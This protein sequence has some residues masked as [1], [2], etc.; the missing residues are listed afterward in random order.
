M[1]KF[2]KNLRT[3]AKIIAF[4]VVTTMFATC[5]KKNGDEDDNGGTAS[6]AG[7]MIN[8]VKW[9]TCNVDAP[10]KFAAKPEA[11]GMFYQWDRKVAWATT[12]NITGWD[13]SPPPTDAEWSKANDP[14]PAGWRV[15]THDDI[16]TLLDL[17]K[18]SNEWTTVNGVGG[19]KFIDNAS[20]N[21]IF[22]PAVGYRHVNDGAL[23]GVDDESGGLGGFYWSSSRST[24]SGASRLGFGS[25][26]TD[27]NNGAGWTLYHVGYGLSV[28]PVAEKL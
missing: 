5:D 23:E 13:V 7:V 16:Q 21:S 6:N 24:N 9:A 3:V 17:V 10:G 8:G 19:R 4:L 26:S 20:G 2:R 11:P 1:F 18:V 12:G 25:G 22:L 14:S 27:D 15:P 28:R